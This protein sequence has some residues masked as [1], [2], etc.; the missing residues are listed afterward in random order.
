QGIVVFILLTCIGAFCQQ[1]SV[2]KVI[3]RDAHQSIRARSP[4]PNSP[5]GRY[6]E[7]PQNY[8][9][10]DCCVKKKIV[11]IEKSRL[12]VAA[13]ILIVSV[14]QIPEARILGCAKLCGTVKMM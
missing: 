8:R 2:D 3:T 7:P 5:S 12:S 14:N 4:K 10:D 11:Q 13:S 1:L 6:A 9:E